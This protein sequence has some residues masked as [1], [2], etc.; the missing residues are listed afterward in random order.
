MSFEGDITSPGSQ[1][2]AFATGIVSAY[3]RNN[4]LQTDQL[5]DLIR[6]LDQGRL[7]LRRVRL[8]VAAPDSSEC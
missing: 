5:P 1:N 8:A 6:I 7:A 2:V 3:V 4:T